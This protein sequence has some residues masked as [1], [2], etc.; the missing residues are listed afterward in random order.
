MPVIGTGLHGDQ[1][2][3]G[4]SSALPLWTLPLDAAASL[5]IYTHKMRAIY[6]ERFWGSVR[7]PHLIVRRSVPQGRVRARASPHVLSGAWP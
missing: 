4:L 5:D 1:I 3:P 6:C 2:S 7:H